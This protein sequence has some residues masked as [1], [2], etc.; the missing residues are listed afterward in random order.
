MNIISI[1]SFLRW[2][3]E[4]IEFEVRPCEGVSELSEE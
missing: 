1:S 2:V 3:E 4:K